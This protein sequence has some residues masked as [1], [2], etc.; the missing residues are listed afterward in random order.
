MTNLARTAAATSILAFLLGVGAAAHIVEQ[1]AGDETKAT[2]ATG[3]WLEGV[4]AARYAQSWD[5]AAALLR[6][7]VTRAQWEQ[8]LG[9]MRAAL[10][11]AGARKLTSAVKTTSLPGAP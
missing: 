2:L 8:Q 3:K 1:A 10:G 6:S 5:Q 7:A 11:A 9:A 4:D